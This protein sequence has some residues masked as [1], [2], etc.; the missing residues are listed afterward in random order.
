MSMPGTS[1]RTE[2]V[3]FLN[4]L[5]ILLV[6]DMAVLLVFLGIV[7]HGRPTA[8]V[9]LLLGSAVPFMAV[10]VLRP[11]LARYAI[12]FVRRTGL[13]S[14]SHIDTAAAGVAMGIG[15]AIV[16]L[17]LT[18]ASVGASGADNRV[19][20]QLGPIDELVE[21]PPSVLFTTAGNALMEALSQ[22]ELR[23][24][25]DADPLTIGRTSAALVRPAS[26]AVAVQLLE[27]DT[28]RA[29]HFGGLAT[30]T[31]VSGKTVAPG[32]ALITRDLAATLK[33][34][35]GSVLPAPFGFIIDGVIKRVGI[36][37]LATPAGGTVP[38]IIVGPGTL[39]RLLAAGWTAPVHMG[40]ALSN[41]GGV[42]DAQSFSVRLTEGI[43]QSLAAAN[44]QGGTEVVFGDDPVA[45]GLDRVVVQ[46]VKAMLYRAEA[47]RVDRVAT[48]LR[49]VS[50]LAVL[51]GTSLVS[52]TVAFSVAGRRRQSAALRT[53]GLSGSASAAV[54]TMSIWLTSLV[55]V[56]AGAM[57][58][59]SMGWLLAPVTVM[60][61]ISAL[62]FSGGL[63]SVVVTL[64]AGALSMKSA[65]ASAVEAR[66]PRAPK[67]QW[68][69]AG[70]LTRLSVR[71]LG[72]ANVGAL[73]LLA[74]AAIV[75]AAG[76]SG[77]AV[78]SRSP[79]FAGTAGTV[80]VDSF[81][82][83][84]SA[85]NIIAVVGGGVDIAE[86]G[87][88]PV[89][90]GPPFT[91]VTLIGAAPG[92]SAQAPTLTHGSRPW[93][94]VLSTPGLA[95]LS[96]DL[97]AAPELTGR[98][99]GDTITVRDRTTGRPV[100]MTLAGVVNASVAPSTM[101]TSTA[102]LTNVAAGGRVSARFVLQPPQPQ[103]VA[104]VL[105]AALAGRPATVVTTT[106]ETRTQWPT[107]RHMHDAERHIV[108][109]IWL[110]GVLG[111][112]VAA[113]RRA[114]QRMEELQSWQSMGAHRMKARA[115]LAEM[116]VLMAAGVALGWCVGVIY[117]N[118]VGGVGYP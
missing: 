13:G 62:T 63:L 71:P 59:A 8:G 67:V 72:N 75:V 115:V 74:A 5:L 56:W 73:G 99:V 44:D 100:P 47:A 35:P 108:G 105:R 117:A 98:K 24:L 55:L 106:E 3:S 9:M 91:G 68:A 110:L 27:L 18:F 33:L 37:G 111:V 21:V 23:L 58:G 60:Q 36:A 26:D 77:A 82:N 11:H 14:G 2:P 41:T 96:S 90:V 30:D 103:R 81:D 57:V 6:G 43:R 86:L 80:S 42:V 89:D 92:W 70:L 107:A 114:R 28:E 102:T 85:Q 94:D 112:A 88:L 93:S 78:M 10:A 95:V 15:A 19:K 17:G 116:A 29:S 76:T 1:E 34:R 31:G 53:A 20:A 46:P 79:I 39:N 45:P 113:M 50:W 38:N 22:P 54:T 101:W 52:L 84:I 87:V 118:F 16:V 109:A 32:H 66:A 40:F 104:M 49:R 65:R 64:V 51:T 97:L 61:V 83:S 4:S 48:D 7:S 25:V 12:R 69:K